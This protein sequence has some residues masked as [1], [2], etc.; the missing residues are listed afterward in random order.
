MQI[1]SDIDVRSHLDNLPLSAWETCRPL[2][3]LRAL[4]HF[5]ESE[6]IQATLRQLLSSPTFLVRLMAAETLARANQFEG[7]VNLVYCSVAR[8]PVLG[9]IQ[10]MGEKDV[11]RVARNV[12]MPFAPHLDETLIDLLVADL[13]DVNGNHQSEVLAVAPSGIVVPRMLGMLQKDSEGDVFAS[14]VLARQ[15]RVEGKP[16]LERA[17]ASQEIESVEMAVVGLT[18]LRDVTAIQKLDAVLR[19]DSALARRYPVDDHP[20]FW[21]SFEEFVRQRRQLAYS[22]EKG[23]VRSVLDQWYRWSRRDMEGADPPERVAALKAIDDESL[24]YTV[25]RRWRRDLRGRDSVA[26]ILFEFADQEERRQI[27]AVQIDL[28]ERLLRN[29]PEAAR[30]AA[31][32]R[33]T[34]LGLPRADPQGIVYEPRLRIAFDEADLIEGAT[35]MDIGAAAISRRREIGKG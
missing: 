7:V 14:Y 23:A 11:P 1:R 21:H 27:H 28:V 9:Y 20:E 15:D 4:P 32:H 29:S 12:L 19:S 30:S 5:S 2:H 34:I 33:D 22:P 10:R 18:H 6:R 35:A 31:F 17:L 16:L 8:H 13:G 3:T 24:P 25:G 26:D